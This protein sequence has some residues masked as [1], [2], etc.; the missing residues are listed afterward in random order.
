MI[1]TDDDDSLLIKTL[2]FYDMVIAVASVFVKAKT[3]SR[4]FS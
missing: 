2:K 3:I 1:N 4:K